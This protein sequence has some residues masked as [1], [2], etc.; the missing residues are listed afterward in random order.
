MRHLPGRVPLLAQDD[1]AVAVGRA[2]YRGESFYNFSSGSVT[3]TAT[4]F[5][6][7]PTEIY[8]CVAN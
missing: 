8:R 5:P 1:L 2:E 6:V 7:Q 4:V 3:A